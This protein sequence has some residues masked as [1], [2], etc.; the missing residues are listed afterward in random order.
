VPA[1]QIPGD[2]AH[3][4]TVTRVRAGPGR[5]A[6]RRLLPRDLLDSPQGRCGARA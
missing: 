6:P 4:T 1:A 2:H 3:A 5:R